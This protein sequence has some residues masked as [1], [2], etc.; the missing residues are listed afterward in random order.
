MREE[1]GKTGR[2]G[3]GIEEVAKTAYSAWSDVTGAKM[4]WSCR[5]QAEGRLT[6]IATKKKRD[7]YVEMLVTRRGNQ[8]E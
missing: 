6:Q 2:Q 5:E 1:E 3:L 7:D 4:A 8:Q